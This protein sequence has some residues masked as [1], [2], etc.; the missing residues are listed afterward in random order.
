ML[1]GKM[2]GINKR[3]CK[4]KFYC[5]CCGKVVGK[6]YHYDLST[7][8]F[9][10]INLIAKAAHLEPLVSA[11]GDKI[12]MNLSKDGVYYE[13]IEK[14]EG[15]YEIKL[16]KIKNYLF[17]LREAI[18]K[19]LNPQHADELSSL[20]KQTY[21][22][23][24]KFKNKD[25]RSINIWLEVKE[26]GIAYRIN[27]NTRYKLDRRCPSCKGKIAQSAG[28][29]PQIVVSVVGSK[30]TDTRGFI[31]SAIYK[32]R[33]YDDRFKIEHI[34]E[35]STF[36]DTK[37]EPVPFDGQTQNIEWNYD[38]TEKAYEKYY[39]SINEEYPELESKDP[40]DRAYFQSNTFKVKNGGNTV[41]LT[42][43]EINEQFLYGYIH[44]IKEGT[45]GEE[46]TLLKNLV[47]C[48][49]HVFFV[50][51]AE[52]S[53]NQ[54]VI[55]GMNI[56]NSFM[57]DKALYAIVCYDSPINTSISRYKLEVNAM[58]SLLKTN[59]DTI[60]N[61]IDLKNKGLQL[62]KNRKC[63]YFLCSPEDRYNANQELS[64]NCELPFYWVLILEGAM[65]V[66][67]QDGNSEL[68][69]NKSISAQRYWS[70]IEGK[71]YLRD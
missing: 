30:K 5:P 38:R 14:L 45:M 24:E 53:G 62:N 41:L 60:N 50:L 16:K 34:S 3:S 65:G 59:R 29:Y 43:V 33:N 26:Y 25:V 9:Y 12:C 31:T 70:R 49:G 23:E 1:G 55:D 54:D 18:D 42:I 15:Q 19:D 10:A 63:I 40:Y 71:L 68:L 20:K 39:T 47:K 17:G 32:I 28:E 66:F 57:N 2:T 36:K 22:L 13:S 69:A 8:Y 21:I 44:C 4:H 37:F 7:M 35:T 6:E 51:D 46:L 48:S 61:K 27:G 52:S 67:V 58:K 64:L 11:N 56:F